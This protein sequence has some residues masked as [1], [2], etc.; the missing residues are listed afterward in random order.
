MGLS[1]TIITRGNSGVLSKSRQYDKD[2]GLD[3]RGA[4]VTSG[5]EYDLSV[6]SVGMHNGNLNAAAFNEFAGWRRI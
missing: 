2:I 5:F 1:M 6:S 3:Y 4:V